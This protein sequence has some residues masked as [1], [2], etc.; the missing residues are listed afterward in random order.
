MTQPLDIAIVGSLCANDDYPHEVQPASNFS[1]CNLFCY[2]GKTS[3]G[4]TAG[5]II[6][7]A[8]RPSQGYAEATVLYF[9]KGATH[10]LESGQVGY[11]PLRNRRED[12]TTHLGCSIWNYQLDGKQEGS[13]IAEHLS[14]SKAEGDSQQ[15]FDHIEV[16]LG[17][18]SLPAQLLNGIQSRAL[19]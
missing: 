12:M 19:N 5:G 7:V 9:P 1:E 14:Q 18:I 17:R 16:S 13:G 10:T 3:S 2:A 11:V 4:K 8:N 15:L 6:R